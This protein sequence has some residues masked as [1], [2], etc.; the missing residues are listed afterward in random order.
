MKAM[1]ETIP[2]GYKKTQVG[3]I[4]KDWK[5]KSLKNF[6]R[7]SSGGTP[8]RKIPS[9]WNGSIPW[10]TTTLIDFNFID[11]AYEFITIS[12]L[13]NSATRLYDPGTLLM[14]MYGQGKTRGKVAML[15]ISATINQACAAIQLNDSV[16]KS[17]IFY[18][19]SS[20]YEEIRG[21]SNTG[22]Q[23][24]LNIGIIESIEIPLP[25]TLD[26]QRAIADALS[27]IDAQ[28][29]A[30]DEE[31]TK[32]R[33]LKQGTMQRLL[34]GEERLPGFDG[35]WEEWSYGELFTLLK[36]GSNP[37]SHLSSNGDV[38]Y[39]HYGDIHQRW[40]TYLD[41][42]VEEL[43]YIDQIRVQSLPYIKDG[44]L[45][46]ADASED[47]EGVGAS[48]E[49]FNSQD[50][51]IVAGLHTLLLRGNEE[52]L[53]DGF[54]GY[55][56]YISSVKKQLIEIATG[57]S[58]YGISKTNIKKIT[59]KL[60]NIDEQKA[61]VNI[62]SDMDQE[63]RELEAQREKTIALKQGMMQDLLTGKTRLI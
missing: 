30:L 33:D 49:I 20:R 53:A 56:Q 55:L 14:A 13:E 29:T 47:Y 1:T 42:N 24:N 34:T 61:I 48:I 8:S 52:L 43:P 36:T 7:V 4:P 60:P 5:V 40:S 16:S 27:D 18:N 9:Y 21:L 63:I 23:E 58:V 31:I 19:L 38:K 2:I 54:K 35:E 17:F 32:K 15:N 57:I 45:V 50:S 11:K 37:R 62:L 28:I 39:I 10:I 25:P 12:G 41:C 59:V 46:M 22:N 51:K 3:I 44:D 26:E 6:A